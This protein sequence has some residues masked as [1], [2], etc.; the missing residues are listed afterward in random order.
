MPGC[1]ESIELVVFAKKTL[2]NYWI[3][4]AELKTV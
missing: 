4:T 1:F 3:H 2:Q